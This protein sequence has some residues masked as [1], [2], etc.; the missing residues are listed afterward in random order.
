MKSFWRSL[1]YSF[2]QNL[3]WIL[4]MTERPG[5]IWVAETNRSLICHRVHKRFE[6][7]YNQLRDAF[8][9]VEK[10]NPLIHNAKFAGKMFLFPFF[11][12]FT[13]PR[14]KLTLLSVFMVFQNY[15][16]LTTDRDLKPWKPQFFRYWI[17]LET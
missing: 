6:W 2:L 11:R 12:Q 9:K 14:V 1:I 10:C 15:L 13:S 17:P 5:S 8:G 7:Y 4:M 16:R 3:L